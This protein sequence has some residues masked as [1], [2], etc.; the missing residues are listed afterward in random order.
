LQ[1][2]LLWASVCDP[3]YPAV[4]VTAAAA[5]VSTIVV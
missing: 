4:T 1:L 2:L 5:F 3:A